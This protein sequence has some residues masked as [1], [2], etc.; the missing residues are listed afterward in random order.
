RNAAQGLHAGELLADVRGL[1]QSGHWADRSRIRQNSETRLADP[2]S[3]EF[4]YSNHPRRDS[5]SRSYART[6]SSQVGPT[7]TL[8]VSQAWSQTAPAGSVFSSSKSA[9][10]CVKSPSTSHW[11]SNAVGSSS[12][13]SS[14]LSIARVPMTQ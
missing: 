13:M 5:T 4:G 12:A 8:L 1:Q 2:N 11:R 3:G 7:G 6:W 9:S 14:A 10:R